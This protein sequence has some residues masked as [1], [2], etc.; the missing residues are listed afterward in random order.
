[1]SDSEPPATADRPVDPRPRY[2][3]RLT[4]PWWWWVAAAIFVG[5]VGYEI[6]LAARQAAWSIVGYVIVGLLVAAVLWS[7]GRP[8]VVVTADR[9]LR[10]GKARLPRSVMA[11]GAVIPP[12]AKS[13]AMGRQLDPAAFLMHHAWV[14]SMVL[15]VLDDPD[16]PTPYWLVSTRR[17]EKVLAALDLTDAAA[18]PTASELPRSDSR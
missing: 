9:E 1:M 7:L 5:L 14:K 11:R 12:S 13:A 4:V 3:E 18:P 2:A 15:L 17:P 16:D 10:A 8:Q 6:Q